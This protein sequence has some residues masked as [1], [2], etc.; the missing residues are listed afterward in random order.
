[1]FNK[2]P[3]IFC[4]TLRKNLDPFEKHDDK[5]LWNVLE[6]VNLKE[7]VESLKEKLKFEFNE[8]GKNLR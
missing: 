7:Y 1:L 2:D 8:S 4:G 5:E 6:K 3:F